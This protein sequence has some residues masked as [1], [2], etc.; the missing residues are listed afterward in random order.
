MG[1]AAVDLSCLDK[2]VCH[3]LRCEWRKFELDQ[4]SRV[5]IVGIGFHKDLVV[6]HLVSVCHFLQGDP[7]VLYL[8]DGSP[9]I[10]G[11]SFG[12]NTAISGEVVFN[13]G[14][15]GYPEALT[16]PSYR[17]QILVLTYPLIGNYGVP[18]ENIKDEHGLPD[19]FESGEIHIAGLVVSSYSWQHS[20][21]AATKSLG[22]WLKERNIPAMHNVDT[23]ELTKKLREHG[24]I[25][26]R[27]EMVRVA[28]WRRCGWWPFAESLTPIRYCAAIHRTRPRSFPPF[29]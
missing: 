13:T 7:A 12:A 10:Q 28:T 26:G 27:M 2:Q 21:W 16:D 29:P 3:V 25:L 9:P 18:D 14:M 6:A 11:E 17:G 22:D 24:S 20:H 23:R 19:F 15:V 5:V 1:G 8:A 4:V